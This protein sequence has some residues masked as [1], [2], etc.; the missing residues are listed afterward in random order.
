MINK[1][2]IFKDLLYYFY[3]TGFLKEVISSTSH[4]HYTYCL[5]VGNYNP[6]Q[7][8]QS[9]LAVN[10]TCMFIDSRESDDCKIDPLDQWPSQQMT[11]WPMTFFHNR[12]LWTVSLPTEW[13]ATPAVF[14]L[15]TAIAKSQS[16]R[17]PMFGLYTI[18]A[19]R[20]DWSIHFF[21][22]HTT[23]GFH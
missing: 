6:M 16:A 1:P 3:K 21:N 5:G 4:L 9:G 11:L 7:D 12:H 22:V 18:Q 19:H 17:S 20:L 10:S 13:Y 15:P 14:T 8:I 23:V 2:F